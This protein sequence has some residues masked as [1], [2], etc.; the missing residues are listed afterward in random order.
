MKSV[1]HAFGPTRPPPNRDANEPPAALRDVQTGALPF[2]SEPPAGVPPCDP[3]AARVALVPAAAQLSRAQA[4]RLIIQDP[5]LT[6]PPPP[7]R[8]QLS[9]LAV[10]SL[11]AAL[12]G[13]LGAIAAIAFGW[14]ARREIEQAPAVRRG[15]ALASVG[16]ALGVLLTLCWSSAI[17]FGVWMWSTHRSG[18]TASAIPEGEASP[19][20]ASTA[21][22]SMPL[23]EAPPPAA[24]PSGN[25]PQHTTHRRVGG[26]SIVDIGV[27]VSVLSEEL[28]KQR[29]EAY[30]QGE[31]VLVMTTSDPCEPCRGVDRALGDPLMQTALRSVRLVRVDIDLF[32]EDLD[33][34]KV[35]R[36]LYPGFFLLSPDLSPQDG[37]NGGEWDDDIARNIAPVL[38]AFVRGQYTTRRQPW[39]PLPGSGMRL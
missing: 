32:K 30:A 10:S 19:E 1:S 6:P 18:E 31:K 39:N 29:A 22:P 27:D 34:I 24:Q 36:R 14:A 11:V 28:A 15:Y 4:A 17:G 5:Y 37:I 35:P 26:V 23:P 9:T 21:S 13:P 3:V 20:P 25:A 33:Q 8:R 38:G 2:E 7:E 16:L 12:F